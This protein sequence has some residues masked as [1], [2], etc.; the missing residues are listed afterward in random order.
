MVENRKIVSSGYFWG[1]CSGVAMPIRRSLNDD[2]TDEK[3]RG[4]D[5]RRV[6]ER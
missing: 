6:M 1:E 2:T 5:M 3:E 4:S